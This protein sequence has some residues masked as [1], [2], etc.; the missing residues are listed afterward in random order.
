VAE[1]MGD[2]RKEVTSC[3]F[4]SA[5]NTRSAGSFL[6]QSKSAGRTGICSA[7]FGH[8]DSFGGIQEAEAQVVVPIAR[9]VPVPAGRP[10]VAS[11]VDPTA[12][13]YDAIR[14]L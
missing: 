6:P 11:V 13:A 3:A 10:H 14:A 8:E 7:A 9:V 12:A 2:R 4:A 5:T 1:N